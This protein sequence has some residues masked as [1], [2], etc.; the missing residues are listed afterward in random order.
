MNDEMSDLRSG[1][2]QTSAVAI[3]WAAA[4]D[5]GKA[6]RLNED[7]YVAADGMFLVADGM[8]GHDAGDVASRLA[9]TVCEE[10]LERVPLGREDVEQLVES[11]NRRVRER[12]AADGTT[13]MGTTL[14]GVLLFDNGG[15]P[16]LIVVNVGDSRCYSWDHDR[17]LVQLTRDHS[18][19]QELVDA[20]SITDAD[21]QIHPE[22]NVITRA[23]GI[24]P[25]VAA[26]FR[27]LPPHD[28]RLLICSDGVSGQLQHDTLGNRLGAA[29]TPDA[30]VAS[31]IGAVLSGP[32]PDNATAIVI[33]VV[34]DR[35][36]LAAPSGPGDEIT[37][38][39]LVVKE[40]RSEGGRV[41]PVGTPVIG[42]IDSVPLAP[43]DQPD[44]E[45]SAACVPPIAPI[46][47][48]T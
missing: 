31:L 18:V 45:V 21:A 23:I 4:T 8:G 7:C 9:I 10:F 1:T 30:V 46:L 29:D 35:D 22:R 41:L 34:W 40:Q 20:G 28:Q 3:T 6:R 12:A 17:G 5:V 43:I 37:E 42:L 32:A 13:G 47:E 48:E 14:S 16:A 11:A 36:P 24:A 38:P 44:R 15:D 19:V 39:R 33:D 27:V 26:D 25:A 2:F